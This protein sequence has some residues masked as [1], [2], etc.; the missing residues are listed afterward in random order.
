M[1]QTMSTN[2]RFDHLGYARYHGHWI[3]K[4]Q[5]PHDMWCTSAGDHPHDPDGSSRF[6]AM[7]DTEADAMRHVRNLRVME[8]A[9][10]YAELQQVGIDVAVSLFLPDDEVFERC[11]NYEDILRVVCSHLE[12]PQSESGPADDLH[13]Y[14]RALDAADLYTK[15]ADADLAENKRLRFAAEAGLER[16]LKV[17]GPIASVARML[18]DPRS[19]VEGSTL[20]ATKEAEFLRA[21]SRLD[22]EEFRSM[23]VV[24]EDLNPVRGHRKEE[25][26]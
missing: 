24:V 2:L 16:L 26:A 21:R 8:I 19:L 11:S 22:P 20:W 17:V 1:A 12:L 6:H 4:P 13:L 9:D 14:D 10:E 5:A 7:H 23:L 15:Q 25:T 3:A 18:P